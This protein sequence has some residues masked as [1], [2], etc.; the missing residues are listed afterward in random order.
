M[1]VSIKN[2]ENTITVVLELKADYDDLW[3]GESLTIDLV[4]RAD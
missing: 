2:E 4:F 1:H 3:M